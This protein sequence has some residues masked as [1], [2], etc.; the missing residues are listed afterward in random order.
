MLRY[1]IS[2]YI[3]INYDFFLPT[4][5]PRLQL[6][7]VSIMKSAK[8]I[9]FFYFTICYIFLQNISKFHEK[10]FINNYLITNY[11]FWTQCFTFL[12]TFQH[13]FT[14]VT[15][16]NSHIPVH[17]IIYFWLTKVLTSDGSQIRLTCIRNIC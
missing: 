16:Q 8:N 12:S 9:F 2:F 13:L 14:F 11:W 3:V 1:R 6:L 7:L 15:W 4:N 10:N 5:I 17:Y